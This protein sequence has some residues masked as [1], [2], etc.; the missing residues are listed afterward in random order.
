MQPMRMGSALD[1][2][3]PVMAS[4]LLLEMGD[5]RKGLRRVV[6]DVR[7]VFRRRDKL[8]SGAKGRLYLSNHC[9]YKDGE[10]CDG[11]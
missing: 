3:V 9:K 11:N 5:S 7:T 4:V 8:G 10:T 6:R 2:F 1:V